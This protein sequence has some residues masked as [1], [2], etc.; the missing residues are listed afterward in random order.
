M[1]IILTWK[2]YRI[3][4]YTTIGNLY[5]NT[6]DFIALL[7]LIYYLINIYCSIPVAT[8]FSDHLSSLL[9]SFRINAFREGSGNILVDN[10][11]G[12]AEN[13]PS[14]QAYS[15]HARVPR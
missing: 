14:L 11:C 12:R 13:R 6:K 8:T 1:R 5:P 7:Y 10:L 4:K 9:I 15:L 3:K 2:I